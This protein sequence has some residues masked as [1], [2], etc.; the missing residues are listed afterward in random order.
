MHNSLLGPGDTEE[1]DH[2]PATEGQGS[3]LA[4]DRALQAKTDPCTSRRDTLEQRFSEFG[5]HKN[6]LT[7]VLLSQIPEPMPGEGQI[8]AGAQESACFAPGD[9][10]RATLEITLL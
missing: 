1:Q 9:S 3:H 6:P 10:R 5:V 4:L 2:F 8:W 7:G